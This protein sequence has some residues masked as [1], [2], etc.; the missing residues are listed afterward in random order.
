M[1]GPNLL[2][3][4]TDE[5]RAD[6]L[7]AYG[8]HHIHTPHLDRLASESVLFEKCYV[9]Q[10]VSTPSRSSI[11]T[12]LYPHAN[13]CTQNNVP[14][15][16]GTPCITEFLSGYRPAYFGKWH[17]GDEIFSQHGFEHW[18]SIED[19]YLPYYRNGRD[20]SERST[21]HHWLVDKGYAPD[22]QDEDAGGPGQFSRRMAAGLPEEH[23]KP[24]FLAREVCQWLEARTHDQPFIGYVNFLEP[25]M[26][27]TGPRDDQ[28]PPGEVALPPNFDHIPD[29]MNH[30]KARMLYERYKC[31]FGGQPLD[32]EAG[33]R[34]VIA[35]YWGLV[36]QVDTA[37]GA[38]LQA[39]RS[40]GFADN[41]I[42]VF[43]SDHGDMMGSH[44][45]LAKS[46]MFQEA[47]TVPCFIK[48]PRV[49]PRREARNISQIDLAPTLLDLLG[50]PIPPEMQGQSLRPLI[51]RGHPPERE[52]VFVEWNGSDC[53]IEQLEQSRDVPDYLAHLGTCEELAAAIRDPIRTVIT[54]DGM[55]LN[56]SPVLGHHGLYNLSEDPYETNNLY[57]QPRYSPRMED[58]KERIRAWGVRVGDEVA[59]AI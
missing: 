48:V 53:G 43:T 26:P 16:D 58:L 47:I 52:D 51:E 7:S 33:W 1:K 37:V 50:Q 45:L 46:V 40:H 35:N 11:M 15:A 59:A 28:Y 17:L 56:Y 3:I 23:G 19:M 13:G 21:Y 42:I 18:V 41:T 29:K 55:K 38:I 22:F 9:T 49:A 36:S 31:G 34:R 10:P 20:R 2:F 8:N 30:P 44:R 12:G 6:T 32:S 14:L 54:P 25:H 5:Q 39:L 4:F 57:G 27:F 24:A